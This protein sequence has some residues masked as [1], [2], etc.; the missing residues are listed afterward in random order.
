MYVQ[1]PGAW[2]AMSPSGMTASATDSLWHLCGRRSLP[3]QAFVLM[4]T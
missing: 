1:G 2:V 4:A 3:A